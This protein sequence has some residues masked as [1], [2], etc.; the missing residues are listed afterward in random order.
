MYS[1]HANWMLYGEKPKKQ[2]KPT[3]LEATQELNR[4]YDVVTKEM[5]MDRA[6]VKDEN[7]FDSMMAILKMEGVVYS[8]KHGQYKP[9]ESRLVKIENRL[10]KEDAEFVATPNTTMGWPKKQEEGKKMLKEFESMRENA[11]L[12]AL[13]KVSLER[14]LNDAEFN[15]MKALGEKHLRPLDQSKPVKVARQGMTREHKPSKVRAHSRHK[16]HWHKRRGVDYY[17]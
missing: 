6:G 4:D 3:I 9:G 17:Y 2:Q 14:P 12:R 1:A 5:I 16:P 8:P 7:H 13:S 11:E 15:K 10:A